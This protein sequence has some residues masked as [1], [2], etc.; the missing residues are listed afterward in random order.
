MRNFKRFLTLALAV[1]MVASVFTFGASAAN[2]T[3]VDADNEYLAD[4]VDLLAYVGVTKGTS[5]TTFG[6]DDLVT[7]EQMAAFIYRLMKKGKSVEGGANVL[8][9][10][11]GGRGSNGNLV[12]GTKMHA[13]V[14]GAFNN[15]AA[16]A[17]NVL[18]GLVKR[19]LVHKNSF[20]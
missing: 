6:T 1:L 4:A 12:C 3:D 19:D 2:F 11:R 16:Y 7:R 10:V 5:E 15:A 17:V 9:A 8:R 13:V 14:V 18:R 20:R